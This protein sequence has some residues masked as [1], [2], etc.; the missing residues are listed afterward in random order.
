[1][2]ANLAEWPIEPEPGTV[3]WIV[4]KRDQLRRA[5]REERFNK[6]LALALYQKIEQSGDWSL[7]RDMRGRPFRSF[8][9]F[10]KNSNG[11]GLERKVIEGRLTAPELARPEEEGGV[12]PAMTHAE[13]GA[14][15]GRGK[16][17]AT[18]RHSFSSESAA[19]LVAR[20]KRD[21]PTIAE[22]LAN[23]EFKS[24]RAAAIAAGILK[25]TPALTELRR[26]GK[27]TTPKDRETFLRE[28]T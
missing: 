19:G 23:G 2:A 14:K 1:M 27:R 15:G 5:L 22:A 28:V 4:T 13:A 12:A 7:L 24:A 26:V 18:E 10:C 9:A 6:E 17:A 3:A 16:K 21:A 25:P 20:L 8:D 11:L